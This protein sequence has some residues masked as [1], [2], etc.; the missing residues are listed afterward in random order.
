MSIRVNDEVVVPGGKQGTVVS[1]MRKGNLVM[2][3]VSVPYKTTRV[4]VNEIHEFRGSELT[5]I[6]AVAQKATMPVLPVAK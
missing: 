2:F 5:K 1:R 6:Q 3:R 4:Q